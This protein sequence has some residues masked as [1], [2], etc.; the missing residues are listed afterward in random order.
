VGV[1]YSDL[2]VREV[3]TLVRGKFDYDKEHSESDIFVIYYAPNEWKNELYGKLGEVKIVHRN[4]YYYSLV[5][6][7]EK[8]DLEIPEKFRL[9]EINS[10]ILDKKL[11]NIDLLLNEM[12]S[13]RD[14]IEDFFEKSFGFCIAKNDK[15]IGWCLSEYNI[16][17]RYEIGIETLEPYRQKG[18]ATITANSVINY[19]ISKGST[20]IGWHCWNTNKSSILTAESLG[21]ER[22]IEYPVISIILSN[23]H[24]KS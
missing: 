23:N 17:D 10:D 15:I 18:I 1:P 24:N 12:Q 3:A 9:I 5:A 7:K 2:I 8:D 11:K 16:G 19:G 20:K 6:S 13:E 14:S 21:F 22:K 4:R